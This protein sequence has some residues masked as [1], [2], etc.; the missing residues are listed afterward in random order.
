MDSPWCTPCSL[1]HHGEA[2]EPTYP[3]EDRV[4]YTGPFLLGVD[5]KVAKVTLRKVAADDKLADVK[6]AL[7]L[8]LDYL[9]SD[10]E[11][12]LLDDAKYFD[13]VTK[14]ALKLLLGYLEAIV[15]DDEEIV[16]RVEAIERR[17]P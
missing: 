4:L 1:W 17:L 12:G 16:R 3:N 2:P 15:N 8:A 14:K 5:T 6:G 10:N 7:M 11:S 13:H 9:E